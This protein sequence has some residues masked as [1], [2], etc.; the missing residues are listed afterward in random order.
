MDLNER[1]VADVGGVIEEYAQVRGELP[2]VGYLAHKFG[3]SVPSMKRYLHD[4]GLDDYPLPEEEVDES[5]LDINDEILIDDDEILIDDD[6]ILIHTDIFIDDDETLIDI[7]EGAKEDI[8]RRHD[9]WENISSEEEPF[10]SAEDLYHAISDP[11][12]QITG[13][14]VLDGKEL[15]SLERRGKIAVFENELLVDGHRDV[16]DMEFRMGVIE[17]A[18]VKNMMAAVALAAVYFPCLTISTVLYELGGKR[19]E[20][21]AGSDP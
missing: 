16:R 8:K 9:W 4:T 3:M 12:A 10:R 20:G 13:F 11:T 7:E 14:S 17:H 21:S 2:D 19:P 18:N 15:V 6:E 5:D 1:H